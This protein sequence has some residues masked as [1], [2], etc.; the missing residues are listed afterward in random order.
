[1]QACGP[2]SNTLRT[3][4]RKKKR[5]HGEREK[6]GRVRKGPREALDL[7]VNLPIWPNQSLQVKKKKNQMHFT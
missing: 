2:S 7:L 3:Y 4:A 1:M 6:G 5:T